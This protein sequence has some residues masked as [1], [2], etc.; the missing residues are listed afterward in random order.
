MLL[1]AKKHRVVMTVHDA[2]ACVVPT[3][4]ADEAQKFVEAA[5]RMRPKWAPDL[6]LDC[7]SGVGQSYGDC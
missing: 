4:K 5:M 3:D 2:I 7:E 6:P 1:I